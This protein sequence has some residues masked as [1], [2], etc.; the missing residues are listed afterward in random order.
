MAE[1][2]EIILEK[3][4][5]DSLSSDVRIS[6]L[7]HLDEKPMTLSELS[8]LMGLSKS[9][10]HQHLSI[11]SE[12]KLIYADDSRKWHPYELTKKGERILHPEKGYKIIFLLGS[13]IFIGI[14]GLIFMYTYIDG[15]TYQGPPKYH[16]PL[17]FLAGEICIIA[18]AV[19]IWIVLRQKNQPSQSE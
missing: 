19:L 12:S 9:T 17:Y 7:K 18:A 10:I 3:S 13:S 5:I 8:D 15:F 6:I 11:L 14:W 1:N 4:D 16:D 2:N